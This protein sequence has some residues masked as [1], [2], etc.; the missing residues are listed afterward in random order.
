MAVLEDEDDDPERSGE[1]DSRAAL[2]A[3]TIE[4]N[5]RV[6]KI[7]VKTITKASTYGKLP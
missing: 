3:S 2:N 6:S 1:R 7:S 5:A 4:R